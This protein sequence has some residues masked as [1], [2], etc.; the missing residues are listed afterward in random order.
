MSVAKK[1]ACTR[2]ASVEN[3]GAMTAGR[4]SRCKLQKSPKSRLGLSFAV[5]PEL[6]RT[7][8]RK[9]V[10]GHDHTNSFSRKPGGTSD[11]GRTIFGPGE[12][13]EGLPDEVF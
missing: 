3:V 9:S 4:N 8:S 11:V 7:G 13:R 5:G 6:E 10:A 2:S 12:P 1:I